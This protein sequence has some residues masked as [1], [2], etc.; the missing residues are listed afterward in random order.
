MLMA[1]ISVVLL[2]LSVFLGGCDLFKDDDSREAHLSTLSISEGTLSP[3]FE[4]GT[5][6][7]SAA[8]DASTNSITVSATP[9]HAGAKAS[10]NGQSGGSAE[11]SLSVGQNVIRVV[12][13]AENGEAQ[14]TY[15]IVVIRP[16]PNYAVGLPQQL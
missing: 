4:T 14:I 11:I 7:Y 6:K 16:V 10:I 12:V 15:T 1:R 3:G 9:V 5:F 8:V 2:L 13:I